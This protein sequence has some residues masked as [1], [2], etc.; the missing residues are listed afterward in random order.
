[1]LRPPD[2]CKQTGTG[3]DLQARF[4][5]VKLN[6]S[7]THDNVTGMSEEVIFTDDVSLSVRCTRPA[8]STRVSRE[9]PLLQL[10]TCS[11]MHECA[12]EG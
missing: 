4:L 7:A 1:M 6:P 11:S 9:I 8:A 3:L 5:L 2:T 12:H 10:K